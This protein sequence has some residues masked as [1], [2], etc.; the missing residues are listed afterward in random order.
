M[1]NRL[2]RAARISSTGDDRL[3]KTVSS[4]RSVC[5]MR[6]RSNTGTLAGTALNGRMQIA[7]H[8]RHPNLGFPKLLNCQLPASF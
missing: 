2:V 5:I 3:H 8:T 7:Q 4:R 1:L 6:A